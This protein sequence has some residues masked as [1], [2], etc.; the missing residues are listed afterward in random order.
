EDHDEGLKPSIK[1]ELGTVEAPQL[2]REAY[3][4]KVTDNT[5]KITGNTTHGLFNGI[6]TLLQLSR[7]GTFV[8]AVTIKDWPAFS[9]RGYMIDVGRNY[10][11][12][13]QIKEQL[14]AMG[15]YKLNHFHFH[16]TEDVAWRLQVKHYP[17]L[18]KAE[19]MT[20]NK[21]QYYTIEQVK[22]LKQFAADRHIE[23]VLEV[24]MPGH[25]AAFERAMGV[26]MQSEEGS[27]IVKNIITEID[28]TYHLKYL[29]IWADEVEIRNQNFIPEMVDLL[30][31][32]G[33][34]TIGWAPG[35]NYDDRTIRQL[36]MNDSI[37]WGSEKRYIDSRALYLNHM[38]PLS[39]VFSV[40]NRKIGGVDKGNKN[41]WGG[42]VAIWNDD[43][44]KA[45][46][47]NLAM[48]LAYPGMLAFAERAWRGGGE[49]GNQTDIGAPDTPRRKNFTDFERRL[50]DQKNTFFK[51]EIF[52]YTAQAQIDWKLYG[53]F[54]NKGNLTTKFWPE[55]EAASIQDSTATAAA[56][57]A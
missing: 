44:V 43:R 34:E 39:G 35:G 31:T 47:D 25:S 29:H 28:T 37:A 3:T 22:E 45:E 50:L 54:Y 24:D 9:Y 38:D 4:L 11:S 14:E 19:F 27:R 6:Q 40:F 52:P 7:D 56:H 57:G 13:A 5:I 46:E 2:A 18:T 33:V 49:K 8:D 1:L 26:D 20:R 42:E 21:G 53:P 55:E 51:D 30:H 48:N 17:E 32:R 12:M 10:Q 15:R 36:W 16:P 23:F 41:V